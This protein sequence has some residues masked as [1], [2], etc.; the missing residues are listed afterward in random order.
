M[1]IKLDKDETKKII[2]NAEIINESCKDI[3]EKI[4]GLE[5]SAF[6]IKDISEQKKVKK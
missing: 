3:V 2:K 4:V 6:N 5:L 1:E